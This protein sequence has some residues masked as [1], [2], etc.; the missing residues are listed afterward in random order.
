VDVPGSVFAVAINDVF[1]GECVVFFKR[2]VRSK[3]VRIGG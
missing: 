3:S 2:V 1:A